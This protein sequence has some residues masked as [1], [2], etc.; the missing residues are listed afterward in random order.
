MKY[1]E[2]DLVRIRSRGWIDAQEKNEDGNIEVNEGH[3]FVLSMFMYA[4]KIAR[5]TK[6]CHNDYYKLDLD[7]S[8][9][10]W[11]DWMFDPDYTS[12]ESP[13]STVDAILTMLH[14]KTLFSKDGTIKYFFN[15]RMFISVIND[16]TS[17]IIST[18]EDKN[19][20]YPCLKKGKRPMT[21]WEILDWANSEES[22]GWLVQVKGV[23]LWNS[24]QNFSYTREKDEYRRARLLP[25][26]S[27]IDESS[28][29]EFEI[30][31]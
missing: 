30:E 23:D 25:D 21:R 11:S 3:T 6:V 27:G 15:G 14:N 24:P 16:S 17:M 8:N 1:K 29:Q 10:K 28:I 2:G 9:W 31:E 18:F 12:D 19:F 13:L 26:K 4:G 22:R 7:V 5:I 20:Y